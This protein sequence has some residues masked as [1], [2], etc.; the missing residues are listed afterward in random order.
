VIKFVRALRSIFLLANPNSWGPFVEVS[1]VSRFDHAVSVSWSQGG[2]DL[3]LLHAIGSKVD[4][5]Y[6]DV[7][8]HHPSRFSVTRHIYQLGWHGVNVE[9]NYDLIEAFEKA[10]PSD[11]NIHAAIGLEATYTFTVFEETAISTLNPKWR[12]KFEKQNQKITKT[13]LI[14][15][16][17][18]RS[19]YDTYWPS[20]AADLL[21]IDAEGSDLEVLQSLDFGTLEKNRF[22]RLLLLET[23]PP[24]TNALATDAVALAISWGYEP[25]V[26][27]SMSTLLRSQT[28]CI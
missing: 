24:V 10:R 23:D 18:L 2:E 8:A 3:A 11:V 15:G 14:P 16:T 13:E 9:A 22:P 26:V 28:I 1:E 20:T 7:G 5:T 12:E 25:L 4:G 19:I 6:L 21:C 27:L 17:T